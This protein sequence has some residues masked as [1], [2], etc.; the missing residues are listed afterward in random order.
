MGGEEVKLIP[1]RSLNF[2]LW[3]EGSVRCFGQFQNMVGLCPVVV[4][5][6][7]QALQVSFINSLQQCDV[8]IA[9]VVI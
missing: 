9:N 2:G 8:G 1:G 6:T 7:K 4:P 5:G 3:D